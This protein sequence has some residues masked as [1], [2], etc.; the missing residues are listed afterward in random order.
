MA[1]SFNKVV[2]NSTP[3]SPLAIDPAATAND[4]LISGVVNDAISDSTFSITGFDAIAYQETTTDTQH[5]DVHR[6]KTATGSEGSL[7]ITDSG[8]EDMIGFILALT[9]ADNT[10]P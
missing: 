4:V 5:I 2:T 7:N 10:T 9:G 3:A 6:K 8:A 1:I